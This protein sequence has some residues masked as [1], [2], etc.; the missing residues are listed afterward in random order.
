MQN[1]VRLSPLDRIKRAIVAQY[2][3]IY[4]RTW[5]EDRVE[6]M[7]QSI[8]KSFSQAVPIYTWTVSEGL[9]DSKSIVPATTEP[10]KALDF[11][12]K[13]GEPG[14]YLLKDFHNFLRD[15]AALARRLRDAY[16]QLKEKARF[17]MILGTSFYIPEE[18][19][20]EVHL[21]EVPLPGD[22]EIGPLLDYMTNRYFRS[23]I[24]DEKARNNMIIGL[25]GLTI[26]EIQHVLN[27][28]FFG[29]QQFNPSMIEQVLTEKEQITKKEGLLEFVFPR[30]RVEDV[31]GYGVLKE[32]LTKRSK[33][34]NK[35][36]EKM[37]VSVPKGLLMMGIS[38]C[39][40]SLA[41]KVVSTLW[42]LPLFRLD[43]SN[44]FSGGFGPPEQAFA[45]AIATIEAISPAVLWIDEIESGMI[46]VKEGAS[47]PASRI[48]ATFLTWMQEKD[49]LV[50]VAATANRIDL[51]PAEFIRKG[52][53][54]QVFFLDLPDEEERKSIF[55]VH[56]QRKGVDTSRFDL[57]ILAKSTADWNG[58]E[59]EQAVLS[60]AVE[61]FNE[62]QPLSQNHILRIVTRTIPLSRTMTEQI[63]YIK[64]WAHTRALNAS[65]AQ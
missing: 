48:F 22:D 11:I 34:F 45:R 64:S 4:L 41:V 15:N 5:E 37:G 46:G 50:F 44:V 51:L 38:G 33:I 36:A 3:I 32:W 53:F 49:A 21:I 20:K 28:L 23:P 6:K 65:R 59:I 8:A 62:N 57:V 18:L 25:K 39:G 29:Q 52:R 55:A 14:F 60:A 35:D 16:Y 47:G 7:V 30:F 17:I 40:K 9:K 54:D 63:K 2:P 61:A 58:A 12:I 10:T 42:N 26:N 1:R 27:A 56:L 13:E 19:S 43:M 24:T 31:G